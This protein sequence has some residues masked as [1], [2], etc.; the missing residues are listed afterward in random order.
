ML[1]PVKNEGI[2]KIFNYC[3]HILRSLRSKMKKN[4]K[5]GKNQN[6]IS[7]YDKHLKI[8]KK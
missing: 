4:L 3:K 5:N 6:V 1:K 7:K 2:F 8:M